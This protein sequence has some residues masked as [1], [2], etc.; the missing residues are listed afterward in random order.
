MKKKKPKKRK[1]LIIVIV[2]SSMIY[3]DAERLRAAESS[4]SLPVEGLTKMAYPSGMQL[5]LVTLVTRHGDRAPVSEE[6]M[7]LTQSRALWDRQCVAEEGASSIDSAI[8]SLP[9]AVPLSMCK[10]GQLTHKG[11]VEMWRTGDVL[12]RHYCGL[13]LLPRVL[14][15]EHLSDDLVRV[16]STF[17]P[18]VRQSALALLEGLWPRATARAAPLSSVEAILSVRGQRGEES[19]FVEARCRALQACWKAR[20]LTAG[21]G[22]FGTFWIRDGEGTR[23]PAALAIN[24]EVKRVFSLPADSPVGS[25]GL[26]IVFF[27][28]NLR[29][30]I[31]HG[32]PLP[33]GFSW[34]AYG[35][36]MDACTRQWFGSFDHPDISRLGIGRL[37]GEITTGLEE[38]AEGRS[39][40]KLAYFSGHDTT[41]APLAIAL[42]VFDNAWPRTAST[43]VIE[44]FKDVR[45]TNA[46]SNDHY[47]RVFYNGKP[48]ELRGPE[49]VKCPT[50]AS[51]GP[52]YHL[53]DVLKMAY[54][55]IPAN[56]E[57]ECNAEPP[58]FEK[59]KDGK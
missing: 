41:I 27:A 59:I 16:R 50:L 20:E 22:S 48:R 44:L 40:T 56:F 46:S 23:S 3:S 19:M 9:G 6:V 28:D 7:D 39:R 49:R 26:P 4:S 5:L 30:R 2:N 42:G 12:R 34:E 37:V 31:A 51:A 8:A 1:L 52:I 58:P 13:G 32:L 57:A 38:A 55:M 25:A 33:S 36:M 11:L 15:E 14:K 35:R 47:V 54:G 24:E 18:R 53:R 17:V 45:T 43:L 21:P 10:A 29:C